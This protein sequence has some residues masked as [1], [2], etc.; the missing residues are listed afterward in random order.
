M[1]HSTP[2]EL[3]KRKKMKRL[4]T[5]LLTFKLTVVL[6]FIPSVGALAQQS[7]R[8]QSTVD[9]T[10]TRTSSAVC[11]GRVMDSDGQ[12]LIGAVVSTNRGQT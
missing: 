6:A 7:S 11:E 3:L 2:L 4:V 9:T 12:P 10:R 8:T 5:V 1:E